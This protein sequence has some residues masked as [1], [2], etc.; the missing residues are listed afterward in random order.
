MKSFVESM[1]YRP[2][3]SDYNSFPVDPEKSTVG[4]CLSAVEDH[5]SI[6]ILIVGG[7]YGSVSETGQSVTNLEYNHA[8]SMGIPR[9]VFVQKNILHNLPIWKMNK[10][11]DFSCICDSSKLFEFVESL[12]DNSDQWVFSFERAEDIIE[13]L[14]H[15]FSYL[16]ANLVTIKRKMAACSHPDNVMTL[17]GEA[18]RLAIE[19]PTAWEYRLFIQVLQDQIDSSKH[20]KWDAEYGICPET[21]VRCDDLQAF[22][23][24]LSG[25]MTDLMRL[26]DSLTKLVNETLKSAWG[27]P[28]VPGNEDQIVYVGM[29]IGDIYRSSIQ[30]GIDFKR[31]EAPKQVQKLIEIVSGYNRDVVDKIEAISNEFRAELDNC[32]LRIANGDTDITIN[33]TFPLKLPENDVFFKELHHVAQ[34]YGITL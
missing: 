4:S 22:C 25:K 17:R 12:R 14:K 27:L 29:R 19:K 5:T 3:M 15:Q 24:Q 32:L 33:L 18:F 30:W 1:G 28:G 7:R 34:T 13:T 11:A 20:L 2:I 23:K 21:T 31:I 16:F 8:K 26:V 6:F 9:Y 10:T